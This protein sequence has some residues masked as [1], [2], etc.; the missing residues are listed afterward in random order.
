MCK[1]YDERCRALSLNFS[2]AGGRA[3]VPGGGACRPGFESELPLTAAG[4]LAH[5]V[6]WHGGPPWPGASPKEI[7]SI[8]RTPS[9]DRPMA[10]LLALVLGPS[11]S[12][13]I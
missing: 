12:L 13:G 11:D 6:P 5:A 7:H 9:H 4:F 2:T 8:D 3:C 1:W 10:S